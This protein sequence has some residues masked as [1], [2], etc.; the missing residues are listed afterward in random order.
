MVYLSNIPIA[1][2]DLDVSQP[3][4]NANFTQLNVSFGVDHYPYD[5]LTVNNGF[6]NQVTTPVYVTSPPTGL[7]PI[8][9]VN[10]LF[11]GF[12]DFTN[13]GTLQ[14]SRGPNNAVPTPVTSGQGGPLNL[15][16]NTA[17]NIWDFTG[18]S[19]ALFTVYAG[20]MV[21]PAPLTTIGVT[22]IYNGTTFQF[23]PQISQLLV[24]NNAKILQLISNSLLGNLTSVYFTIVFHR[25]Q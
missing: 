6:H 14:Y 2:D 24:Q 17:Q 15:V 18:I 12:K 8:T 3:Q 7:A 25:L 13:Q 9:G 10:P 21:S 4:L 5:N 22:G 23:E 20:D 19:R 11:Y 16:F 1:T